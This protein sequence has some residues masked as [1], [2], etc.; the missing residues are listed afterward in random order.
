MHCKKA[1][2]FSYLFAPVPCKMCNAFLALILSAL[3]ELKHPQAF[4]PFKQ[5]AN[6]PVRTCLPC[7]CHI[8]N[9]QE[10]ELWSAIPALHY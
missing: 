6:D 9:Q 2:N 5:G 4:R 7:F 10:A 1:S 3:P 8:S